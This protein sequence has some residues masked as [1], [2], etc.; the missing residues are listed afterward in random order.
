MTGSRDGEP[1]V[2]PT[3][4]AWTVTAYG[5]KHPLELR[6]RP[7]PE[8]GERDLLVRVEAAGVNPLDVKT[9]HGEFKVPLP[10]RTPFV[11]GNDVAGTVERVGAGV[12]R[13]AVG[14][15]V[16]ARVDQRRVGTFA[17]RVAVAEADCAPVPRS[18]STVEAASLPLVALTA[19]QALV[20]RADVRPGQRVLVHAGAGGVGSMAIQLARHLGAHVATTASAANAD[21]V[22]SSGADE[23]V[24]HRSEDF[25]ARLHDYDVVLDPLGEASVLRSLTVLRPGGVVVG[26]SGPP[27]PA[28]ATQLGRPLLRPVLALTSRKVRAAARRRGVRYTFLFMTA[29]GEQLRHVTDLVDAGVLRPSVERTYGFADTPAALA[30]VAGGRTRGKIVVTVP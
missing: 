2:P 16:Y 4:R 26:I 21:L 28:F 3:T 7:T 23:V 22:R 24:D 1:V 5:A 30:Q 27:D 20:V 11:L 6:E 25:T 14:D 29:D 12:T 18:V 17:E 10:Y 19:W 8:V 13:F 15:A 9:W